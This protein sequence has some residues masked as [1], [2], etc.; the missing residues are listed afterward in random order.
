VLLYSADKCGEEKSGQDAAEEKSRTLA[1]IPG[2]EYV[3]DSILR[4]SERKMAVESN[5]AADAT[6]NPAET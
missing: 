5:S 2:R 4:A 6:A 1:L 3:Y